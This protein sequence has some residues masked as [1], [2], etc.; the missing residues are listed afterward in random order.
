MVYVIFIADF[1]LEKTG[2][3]STATRLL[4]NFSE[5]FTFFA[6]EEIEISGKKNKPIDDLKEYSIEN[7]LIFSHLEC[8]KLPKYISI[9]PNALVHVGD[10]PGNYW[11][12]VRSNRSLLVG[13]LGAVR[14]SVRLLRVPKTTKLIFVTDEDTHSARRAGY[15]FSQTLLIG[16][17]RPAVERSASLHA[18]EL[19]F[20]GNFAYRPNQQAAVA[21]IEFAR[22]HP[23][24][25]TVL[26]GFNANI[27]VEVAG[28]LPSNVE[29]Y[30]NLPSIV[31]FLSARRR[32]Y[33]SLVRTGAGAK[34]KILEALVSGCPVVATTESLDASLINLENI[35]LLEEFEELRPILARIQRSISLEDASVRD[36]NKILST[37]TWSVLSGLL[38]DMLVST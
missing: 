38:E 28:D 17:D 9:F 7:C 26:A 21:L 22:L 20:T 25:V 11:R 23:S 35:F 6:N 13:F 27:L 14:L 18:S 24:Y 3:L 15:D 19:V 16:V 5:E 37:R 29:L 30:E 33:V 2:V 1:P 31:D 12:T 36:V 8:S 4:K 34:N 10:W 32:I